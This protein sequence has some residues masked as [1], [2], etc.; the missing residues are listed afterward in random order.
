MKKIQSC[1]GLYLWA[2]VFLCP[3][4]SQAGSTTVQVI[5]FAFSPASSS[6]NVGDTIT[7]T[8]TG[9]TSHTSTSGNTPTPSGLWTSGFLSPGMT[10]AHQFTGSGNF[11]YFCQVHPFMTGSVNVQSAATNVPP[12][13]SIRGPTDGQLI[14]SWSPAGGVLQSTPALM[15]MSTVWTDVGMTNPATLAIGPGSL[16]FRVK[17]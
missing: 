3:L 7:W 17:Q 6:V 11:P 2:A 5:D 14:V 4:G 1:L 16:F 10:F 8:N 15:G 13:L 12:V 9:T